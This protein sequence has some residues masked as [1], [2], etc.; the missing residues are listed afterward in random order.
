MNTTRKSVFLTTKNAKLVKTNTTIS[1]SVK[2]IKSKKKFVIAQL[3]DFSL[4]PKEL[5]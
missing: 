5:V 2:T 3:K 1:S 4:M